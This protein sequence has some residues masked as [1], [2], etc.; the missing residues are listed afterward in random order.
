MKSN[1]VEEEEPPTV[2]IKISGDE[3]ECRILV[4]SLLVLSPCSKKVN[5]C[6][7]VQVECTASYLFHQFLQN[8]KPHMGNQTYTKQQV[9]QLTVARTNN[10][11]DTKSH[12]KKTFEKIPA[13]R[14]NA[15]DI[16]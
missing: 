7:P 2:K 9:Q 1:H 13:L 5:I 6:S 8:Y 14:C 10:T 4:L 16:N 12:P 11:A 3:Q 15:T